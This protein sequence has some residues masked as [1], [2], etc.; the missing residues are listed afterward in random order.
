MNQQ[1]EIKAAAVLW[2]VRQVAAHMGCGV[3]T[4]WR[5]KTLGQIPKP[6]KIGGLVRWRREDIER[7]TASTAAN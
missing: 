5:W 1:T 7:F 6:M 3:S 2:D 4:V